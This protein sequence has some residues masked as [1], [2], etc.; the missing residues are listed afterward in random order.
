[1][2][3]IFQCL[4][5]VAYST[6]VG[7]L[8]W[9]LFYWITPY[10]MSVG[11]LLFFLYIFLAGGLIV[12]IVAFIN[13]LLIVPTTFLMKNNIVAKVINV[14]PLL[15]FGYSSVRLPWGLDMDYGVLQYLIGISLTITI[16]ISFGSMIIS[17]FKIEDD[18]K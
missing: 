18:S 2:K 7:Y 11:W 14:F 15:F 1:M 5:T 13:G 6:I 8:L 4:G 9:L 3:K 17:P 16:L 10:I 12:G